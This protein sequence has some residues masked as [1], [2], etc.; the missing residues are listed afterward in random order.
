M[1]YEQKK[2]QAIE[3]LA[4]YLDDFS[5][6]VAPELFAKLESIGMVF[7]DK[8]ELP[9]SAPAE[10]DE[11]RAYCGQWSDAQ[12]W[13]AGYAKA[14]QYMRKAGFKKVLEADHDK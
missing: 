10:E 8:Q 2:A 12:W 13:Y 4:D 14:Q 7:L 9:D 3:I 6:E 1:T 5:L 11:S